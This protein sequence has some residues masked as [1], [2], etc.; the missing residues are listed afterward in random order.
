M[1]TNVSSEGGSFMDI[2]GKLVTSVWNTTEDLAHK[3]G[4]KIEEQLKSFQHHDER[5]TLVDSKFVKCKLGKTTSLCCVVTHYHGISVWEVV[6]DA[7]KPKNLARSSLK[8][9]C[10]V[11]VK[12]A[13]RST[14][15]TLDWEGSPDL[16]IAAI[17]GDRQ[18][19]FIK[20]SQP[21]LRKTKTVDQPLLNIENG[22]DK[23][24]V[25]EPS[26]IALI[27]LAKLSY[28]KL[29]ETRSSV[30]PSGTYAIGPDWIAFC[31]PGVPAGSPSIEHPHENLDQSEIGPEDSLTSRIGNVVFDVGSHVLQRASDEARKLGTMGMGKISQLMDERLYKTHATIENGGAGSKGG[32]GGLGRSVSLSQVRE[33]DSGDAGS[34]ADGWIQ[35]KDMNTDATI[36]HYK[37]HS[38]PIA[39]IK[40]D[41]N[42]SL[43]A[44]ATIYGQHVHVY[45]VMELS[46]KRRSVGVASAPVG[47]HRNYARGT[48]TA[49]EAVHMYKLVRG[50]THALIRDISFSATSRWVAVSSARGTCHVFVLPVGR[51]FEKSSAPRSHHSFSLSDAHTG[52]MA[53][54]RVP[55]V[56]AV[57]HP[58][59]RIA[60]VE[61]SMCNEGE[62]NIDEKP[63]E[64]KE[65]FPPPC[66]STFLTN[67]IE[68]EITIAV[69]GKNGVASV[70]VIKTREDRGTTS[71][72]RTNRVLAK[73]LNRNEEEAFTTMLPLSRLLQEEEEEGEEEELEKDELLA[74]AEVNT[75]SRH[76][77]PVYRNPGV[78]MKSFKLENLT[79]VEEIEEPA[80]EALPAV[81][82]VVDQRRKAQFPRPDW[83]TERATVD[84]TLEDGGSPTEGIMEAIN[85]AMPMPSVSSSQRGSRGSGGDSFGEEVEEEEEKGQEEMFDIDP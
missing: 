45:R 52:F 54:E 1:T 49:H 46:T 3:L 68:K 12:N 43:I 83:P 48:R 77:M 66:I 51:P 59:T 72:L 69:A 33:S 47:H 9:V 85:M 56:A 79:E 2:A 14:V 11:P 50:T 39:V 13:R 20:C 42:G 7:M 26:R 24:V 32:S 82:A 19:L 84:G 73:E 58:L 21:S 63:A 55:E 35:V 8:E 53:A 30:N 74:Q 16:T 4:G 36:V 10:Y 34:A 31:P 62:K 6:N 40:F 70:H 38:S 78:N 25:I 22:G 60:Q 41:S 71:A 65:A 15:C 57:L 80:Y 81:D 76:S 23:L 75:H 28:T 5:C 18:I 27:D 17:V 37:A 61:A 64:L 29:V 44:S 67:G